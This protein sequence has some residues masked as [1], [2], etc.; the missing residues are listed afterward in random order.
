MLKP[1]GD[2]VTPD[3]TTVASRVHA[4]VLICVKTAAILGVVQA[5]WPLKEE[6]YTAW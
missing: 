1:S 3:G 5:L 4:A 6:D 2:V